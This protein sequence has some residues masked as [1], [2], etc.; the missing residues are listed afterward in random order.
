M[1]HQTAPTCACEVNRWGRFRTNKRTRLDLTSKVLTRQTDPLL[2]RL[3]KYTHVKRKRPTC[4]GVF[5]LMRGRRGWIDGGY[6]R[7]ESGTRW[8]ERGPSLRSKLTGT[9]RTKGGENNG[10]GSQMSFCSARIGSEL[11]HQHP[12]TGTHAHTH[13]LHA[14][15]ENRMPGANIER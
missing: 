2:R 7:S 11:G 13:I 3:C 6:S 5:G 12:S 15:L 8:G 9:S 1:Q 14:L 4:G 10:D